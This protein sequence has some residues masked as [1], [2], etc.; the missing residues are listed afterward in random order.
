MP[1]Y[2]FAFYARTTL[3]NVAPNTITTTNQVEAIIN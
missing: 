3:L 1:F 2:F